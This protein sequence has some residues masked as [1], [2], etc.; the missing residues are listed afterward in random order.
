MIQFTD[1]LNPGSYAA[2]G[3][4]TDKESPAYSGVAQRNAAPGIAVCSDVRAGT[5]QLRALREYYLPKFEQEHPNDYTQ[6][7]V[8]ATLYN[9][10]GRTV[11][12]LTGI[13]FRKPMALAENLP[14]PL[15]LVLMDLDRLGTPIQRMVVRLFG[16][17]L[18]TG[19]THVLVDMP[20]AAGFETLADERRAG[21]RPYWVPIGAANVLR[22]YP[23]ASDPSRLGRFAYMEHVTVPQ[24]QFGDIEMARVREY[25][26]QAGAVSYR[27]WTRVAGKEKWEE[28]TPMTTMSG[29]S[30]IPVVT[31]YTNRTGFFTSEPPL[32][33]LAMEN[34]AHF[35]ISSDRR[36]TLHKIGMPTPVITGEA[37][38]EKNYKFGPSS[39]LVLPDPQSKAYFL[40]PSGG[41]LSES[42]EELKD[43]EKRMAALGLSMLQTDT[44]A[45]E[46]AEAHRIS[47]E[48]TT[49]A[50]HLA[51]TNVG[52]GLNEA[53]NLTAEWMG[54]EAVEDPVSLN[55]DFDDT[56]LDADKIEIYS[57]LVSERQLS[58]ET[59]WNLLRNGE[60]L[61]SSFDP[62]AELERIKADLEAF[63]QRLPEDVV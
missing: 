13:A 56:Y 59:F 29:I 51:V 31:M 47:R 14:E 60:I 1:T 61:P 54:R 18:T 52:A 5:L 33:D 27:S 38:S 57:T 28:E 24:G 9:A 34:V 30:R 32:L 63:P 7:T 21:V 49:S 45:A 2:G 48:Q 6:R 43:I 26:D 23:S 37:D 41:G 15:V 12:G 58:M 8:R 17:A 42:R 55:M 4:V 44:R 25:Y 20:R 16:A 40:E 36:T 53:V 22:A 19:H 46:T 62:E 35:Q 39:A 10:L 3:L 11:E 50:L